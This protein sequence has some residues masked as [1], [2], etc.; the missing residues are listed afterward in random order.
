MPFHRRKSDARQTTEELERFKVNSLLAMPESILMIRRRR[1]RTLHSPTEPKVHNRLLLLRPMEKPDLWDQF[2]STAVPIGIQQWVQNC[3][4]I[5]TICFEQASKAWGSR[6]GNQSSNLHSMVFN[7]ATLQ[8]MRSLW[9]ISAMNSIYMMKVISLWNCR[10]WTMSRRDY[11]T[12]KSSIWSKSTKNSLLKN[13]SELLLSSRRCLRLIHTRW[14]KISISLWLW[15]SNMEV[16][17][18]PPETSIKAS[19]KSLIR[20]STRWK[21]ARGS[22]PDTSKKASSKTHTQ[23]KCSED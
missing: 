4:T 19:P 7:T 8:Q 3:K 9:M 20:S 14:K 1:R 12:Q 15:A 2:K 13:V 11:L 21:A 22:F 6:R 5:Y 23:W 17:I 18:R 10:T 16:K